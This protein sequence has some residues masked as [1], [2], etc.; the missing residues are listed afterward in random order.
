M[1]SAVDCRVDV[2]VAVQH[3]ASRESSTS[4]GGIPSAVNLSGQ[5]LT[6]L[7]LF[8]RVCKLFGNYSLKMF[9][10]QK[11]IS[12]NPKYN[13]HKSTPNL[14]KGNKLVGTRLE[15]ETTFLRTWSGNGAAYAS[16]KVNKHEWMSAVRVWAG[17]NQQIEMLKVNTRDSIGMISK[18]HSHP[19]I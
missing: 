4:L 18:T 11:K 2:R 8:C 5:V 10:I 16:T 15:R 14:Q 3:S 13:L 17:S 6:R 19:R 12:K 9:L 7:V 1:T